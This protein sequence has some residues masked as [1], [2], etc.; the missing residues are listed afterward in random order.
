[1]IRPSQFYR[2]SMKQKMSKTISSYPRTFRK[3]KVIVATKPVTT[4]RWEQ[5]ERHAF[6]QGLRLHGKGKWK[7]IGNFVPTR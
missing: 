1:M 4:G 3:E 7:A 2:S 6:L 5:H